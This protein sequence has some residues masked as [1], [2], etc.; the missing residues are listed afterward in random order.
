MLSKNVEDLFVAKT[1]F[2]NGNEIAN[3]ILNVGEQRWLVDQIKHLE[4]QTI[5]QAEV[6]V[7]PKIAE[8]KEALEIATAGWK[9]C[10]ISYGREVMHESLQESLRQLDDDSDWKKLNKL[11]SNFTV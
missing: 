7:M 1:P 3:V 4:A 8:L 6:R 5:G 11:L 9:R 10:F 2:N